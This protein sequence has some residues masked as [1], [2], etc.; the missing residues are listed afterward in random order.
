ME[1]NCKLAVGIENTSDNKRVIINWTKKVR[2]CF[3]EESRNSLGNMRF[4]L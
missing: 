1:H 2:Q 3:E 4:C